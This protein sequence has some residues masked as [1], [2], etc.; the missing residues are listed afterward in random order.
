MQAV[1]GLGANLGSPTDTLI[2]AATRLEQLGA[3][4][5]RSAFYDTLPVGGPE[6]PNFVNAAVLLDTALGPKE[7]LG[8]LLAIEVEL[9]RKR[10]V[11]WGARAIDLDLLWIGATVIDSAEL[12]VPHPRLQERAFAL[13]PLLDVAPEA[14][15]P[16]TG[17]RYAALAARADRAHVIERRDAP[18]RNTP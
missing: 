2:E 12:T 18:W 6:Q 16:R 4:V 9:G 13:L 14:V 3:V 11:R 17:E 1:V 7:L 5:G 15:D 8:R 10:E